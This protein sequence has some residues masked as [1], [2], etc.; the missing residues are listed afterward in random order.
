[1]SRPAWARQAACWPLSSSFLR[2]QSCLMIVLS[3]CLDHLV[4]ARPARNKPPPP[5]LCRACR[6]RRCRRHVGLSAASLKWF[7]STSS[8]AEPIGRA[9]SR[10][11]SAGVTNSEPAHSARLASAAE[12]PGDELPRSRPA[13]AQRPKSD[14]VVISHKFGRTHTPA[15]RGSQACSRPARSLDW[16]IWLFVVHAGRPARCEC[17]DYDHHYKW[18]RDMIRSLY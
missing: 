14:G 3:L 15:C 8:S 16:P 11:L 5:R 17:F 10:P 13:P 2:N 12:P 4:L 9:A 18:P 7:A 1:L 6:R